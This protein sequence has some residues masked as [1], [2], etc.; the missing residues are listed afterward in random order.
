MARAGLRHPLP[1]PEFTDHPGSLLEDE[2]PPQPLVD[3]TEIKFLVDREPHSG[4]HGPSRR[5]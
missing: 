3:S 2:R 4:K 1:M 5:D